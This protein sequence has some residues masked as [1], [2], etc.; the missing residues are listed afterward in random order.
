MI[1]YARRLLERRCDYDVDSR[2]IAG[3]AATATALVTRWKTADALNCTATG[4]LFLRNI[5]RV[6]AYLYAD[7]QAYVVVSRSS[8]TGSQL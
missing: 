5:L 3:R 8:L 1:D 6:F 4:T 2:D 7:H